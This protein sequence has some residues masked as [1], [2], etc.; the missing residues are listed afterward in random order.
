MALQEAGVQYVGKGLD[1]YLRGIAQATQAM[2]NFG[3]VTKNKVEALALMADTAIKVS[4]AAVKEANAL[5]REG[6]A[7][8]KTQLQI[9]K[10][11]T[12]QVKLE[13]INRRAEISA[14]RAAQ[15]QQL[16]ASKALSMI[17]GI[18]GGNLGAIGPWGTFIQM[19]PQ[20]AKMTSIGSLIG[21]IGSAFQTLGKIAGGAFN[22]IVGVGKGAVSVLQTL[23]SITFDVVRTGLQA[24]GAVVNALLSPIRWLGE[25][26]RQVFVVA[27]G[28][29]LRDSIRGAIQALKDLGNMLFEGASSMQTITIRLEGMMATELQS[30]ETTLTFAQALEK[31][32]GATQGLIDWINVL[33]VKSPFERGTIADTIALGMAL[34]FT[35]EQAK[36]ITRALVDWASGMGLEQDAITRILY[37]FG[38]MRAQGKLTGQE[39]RDAARGGLIP[40][41]DI[42]RRLGEQAG[43]TGKALEDAI[44]HPAEAFT[45]SDVDKFFAEFIKM[46]EERF[47]NAAER[48]SRTWVGVQNNIKDFIKTVMGADVLTPVLDRIAGKMA[49]MLNKMLTPE[50]RNQFKGIGLSLT[51]AFD[52]IFPAIQRVIAAVGRFGEALGLPKINAYDLAGTIE[53]V[54]D[55]IARTLDSAADTVSTWATNVSKYFSDL[56]TNALTYGANTAIS[57]ANGFIQ[58]VETAILSA[59]NYLN[60]VLTSWLKGFSPPK[61]APQIGKWGAH[62]FEEWLKGFK[63]ADFTVLDTVGDAVQNALNALV[64]LGRL[65]KEDVGGIFANLFKGLAGGIAGGGFSDAFLSKLKSRLGEF[66]GAIVTLLKDQWAYAQATNA[67]AEAEKALTAAQN[68]AA[69]QRTKVNSLIREYN[70]ALRGGAGKGELGERLGVIQAEQRTLALKDQQVTAADEAAKKAKE[71]ADALKATADLQAKL[72]SELVK[73]GQAYAINLDTTAAVGGLSAIGGAAG[74]AGLALDELGLKGDDHA[75]QWEKNGTD[76]GVAVATAKKNIEQAFTDIGTA[77][78]TFVS[79]N[80]DTTNPET[81]MGKIKLSFDQLQTNAG[82]LASGLAGRWE[83]IKTDLLTLYQQHLDPYTAS[84]EVFKII[85]GFNKWKGVIEGIGKWFE[86]HKAGIGIAMD[87]IWGGIKIVIWLIIEPFRIWL[88]ILQ[89][90]ADTIKWINEHPITTVP[91]GGRG[92]KPAPS[93]NEGTGSVTPGNGTVYLP[94]TVSAPVFTPTRSVVVE[95]SGGVF[96]NN[97]MDLAQLQAVIKQTVVNSI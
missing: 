73:L 43:L 52:T 18:A 1:Q 40:V 97:G 28:V 76:I 27:L 2:T 14:Q 74:A 69:Q 38:Q 79:Q 64:G 41:M 53:V 86:A 88:G 75:R 32:K 13:Q 61:V 22:I 91:P 54:A 95:F 16:S 49:D 24:L 68:A 46:A 19:L 25:Q 33:A 50:V 11:A 8:E 51:Y 12:E 93:P 29:L 63:D 56:S 42:L 10:L 58:G 4:E 96:I 44:H 70:S 3:N 60:Q 67:A 77:I 20:L 87:L 55:W 21:G 92:G 26:I 9:A 85:E 83:Q 30:T 17:G 34:D 47:P 65:K 72:V 62:T 5:T 78:Q 23:A 6:L 7:A 82:L 66:G 89:G 36:T 81:T 45:G 37:N 35:S 94:P 71:Q 59:M 80:F 15:A 39:L 90:I 31:A 57:W 48:M 84:T